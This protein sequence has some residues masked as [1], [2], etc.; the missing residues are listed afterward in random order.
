M[1]ITADNEKQTDFKNNHES[2]VSYT[3]CLWYF[4]I[5]IIG[6]FVL[7]HSSVLTIDDAFISFRYSMRLAEGQGFSWNIGEAPIEG[8]SNL[9]WVIVM[10]VFEVIGANL[11]TSAFWVSG[12]LLIVTACLVFWGVNR[13]THP[14][15]A[16]IV[17]IALFTSDAILLSFLSG[18]ETSLYAFLIAVSLVLCTNFEFVENRLLRVFQIM[19]LCLLS[20]TRFEGF[21]LALL[22][23]FTSMVVSTRRFQRRYVTNLFLLLGFIIFS[24]AMRYLIFQEFLPLPTQAKASG[25]SLI[26]DLKLNTFFRDVFPAGIG[27]I[28]GFVSS[29]VTLYSLLPIVAI[30]FAL[31]LKPHI[32]GNV[33]WVYAVP[34]SFLLAVIILNGGDWM[35][36]YRLMTP[37]IA[38]VFLSVPSALQSFE[39]AKMR[40]RFYMLLSVL[41]IINSAYWL[42][43]SR[44]LRD[45]GF[46]KNIPHHWDDVGTYLDEITLESDLLLIEQI[47]RIGYYG[48]GLRI[49]DWQGLV[50]K[51]VA[52]Q[53]ESSSIFGKRLDDYNLEKYAH[54]IQTGN[55][56][57]AEAIVDFYQVSSADQYLLL[58]E[59]YW[60]EHNTYIF[61]RQDIVNREDF[62]LPS[63]N[64]RLVKLNEAKRIIDEF[65]SN[66]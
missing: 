65:L 36:G 45:A 50:N 61:L 25:L 52:K 5:V 17:A 48:S 7:Y 49:I 33:V 16:F 32:K 2:I 20:I 30:V 29:A 14:V 43:S 58:Q 38:L 1:Y 41:I 53:G 51:T 44:V 22:I 46:D 19:M 27:Y 64:S 35:P 62:V 66:S 57:Y 42:G 23:A 9:L 28:L 55:P 47:G 59:T 4:V 34:L 54:V 6:M 60:L 56:T 12:I 21:V 40:Q 10:A 15:F 24:F 26:I 3:N 11:P 8:Y 31:L 18:L 13:Y 63:E 39:N 37:V